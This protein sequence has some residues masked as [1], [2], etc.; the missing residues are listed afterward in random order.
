[1]GS[2]KIDSSLCTGCGLCES[3]CPEVFKV[4]DDNVAKIIDQKCVSCNVNDVA[5]DC[6]V[7]AIQVSD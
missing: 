5:S 1:M 2:V 6:P 7:G 4:G 3:I